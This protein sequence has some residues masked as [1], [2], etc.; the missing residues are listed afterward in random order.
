M[1]AGF[2]AN[3]GRSKDF[4]IRGGEHPRRAAAHNAGRRFVIVYL[5]LATPKSCCTAPTPLHVRISQN[6]GIIINL[7]IHIWVE[8][9]V[10]NTIKFMF[11]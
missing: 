9:L 8:F 1:S 2:E 4:N 7:L 3:Q 11:S 6:Q 5:R 10:S